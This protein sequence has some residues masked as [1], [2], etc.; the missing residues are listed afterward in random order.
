MSFNG[1]C[2]H[3]QYAMEFLHNTIFL[4]DSEKNRIIAAQ[5]QVGEIVAKRQS[6]DFLYVKRSTY[7]RLNT[8]HPEEDL[9]EAIHDDP[10]VEEYVVPNK[11]DP[12]VIDVALQNDKDS[13]EYWKN[14]TYMG[15]DT[16]KEKMIIDFI[17]YPEDVIK[18]T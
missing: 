7:T 16:V 1:E 17:N 2:K 3:C 8:P 4:P 5:F 11:G 10:K 6:K 18:R 12:A 13:G 15:K 9:D 14:G